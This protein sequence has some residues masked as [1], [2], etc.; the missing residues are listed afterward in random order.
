M[1]WATPAEVVVA[2]IPMIVA[3]IMGPDITRR[4][5]LDRAT[6][7]LAGESWREFPLPFSDNSCQNRF[8]ARSL[9]DPFTSF[10]GPARSDLFLLKSGFSPSLTVGNRG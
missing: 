5:L 4:L 2:N 7:R 3:K 1:T 9:C 6:S 10:K 8:N